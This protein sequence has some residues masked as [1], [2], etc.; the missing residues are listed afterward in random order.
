MRMTR[1]R[2]PPACGAGSPWHCIAVGRQRMGGAAG[3][4][5]VLGISRRRQA[6]HQRRRDD[7][8]APIWRGSR[9]CTSRPPASRPCKRPCRPALGETGPQGGRRPIHHHDR[10]R[11][12]AGHLRGAGDRQVWRLQSALVRRRHAERNRRGRAQQHARQG[13]RSAAGHARSTASRTPPRTRTIYKFNA[14]AGQRV[15]VDCWA[16]RIDSRMDA[17]LVLYD[18]AGKELDRNRDT[19]R[20]DPLLDFTVPA[21]G[22]YY[23]EVHDFLYR[24]QQRVLLPAVD[25]HRRVSRLRLSAR[26]PAGLE[27]PIH[28]VRPQPARRAADQDRV[29]ST[30]SRW[31]RSSCRFRCRPIRAC[32]IWTPGSIVEPDESGIDGMAY[33]LPTPS[34]LTNSVLVGFATAPVVAEQEPNDDPAH[35]QAVSVPCEYVGQFYPQA[36][37]DWITFQA[38]AG[39]ALWMEVFLAAAGA[40]DRS[41]PARA[42]S[43]EERQ[44]RRA[45]QGHSGRRRLPARTPATVSAAPTT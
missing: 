9:S 13:H 44:G 42:A 8:R 2:G 35:A 43:H 22:V 25:R 21:D 23:V 27:R 37:R 1:P 34:G 32:K 41:L 19:N 6:G 7:R 36:D 18:A 17:T 16:Y 3:G 11:R 31:N 15:I 12:Q 29:G 10:R 26:R 14:K 40:A 28:A 45:G 20:R 30:A 5:A 4:A 38:K 39:E 33:R 24:R